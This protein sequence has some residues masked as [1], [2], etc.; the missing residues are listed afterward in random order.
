MDIP[1]FAI[2][3]LIDLEDAKE[4]I[5]DLDITNNRKIIVDAAKY[6]TKSDRTV[7]GM[8]F[9][10]DA[11]YDLIFERTVP[12]LQH[13][14]ITD[15]ASIELYCCNEKVIAKYL[16]VVLRAPKEIDA[17]PILAA[18]SGGLIDLF[19]LRWV[20]HNAPGSPPIVLK[21]R[22][23]VEN[24]K[25][26]V[27]AERILRESLL[28]H[29]S[30]PS[31]KADPDAL[32]QKFQELR[33]SVTEVMAYAVNGH[34]FIEYLCLYLKKCHAQLFREDR[35]G[36]KDPDT[37]RNSLLGCLDVGDLARENLFAQL[38]KRVRKS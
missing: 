38:L 4:R 27:D 12:N 1:V 34:D 7:H 5:P 29:S 32:V 16:R 24:D 25:L 13:L 15:Y 28:A 8:S 10:I 22:I 9:V 21:R 17:G 33:E 14:L 19:V 20:L 2:R 11:D 36:F 23:G 3:D 18:I 31:R 37:A 30:K 6:F 35:K 26:T